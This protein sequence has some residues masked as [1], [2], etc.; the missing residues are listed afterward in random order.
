VPGFVGEGP[1]YLSGRPKTGKSWLDLG[2]ALAV[3]TGSKA[4]GSVECS[5]G[6]G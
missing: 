4:F 2:I 1:E 6:E 3:A 5:K